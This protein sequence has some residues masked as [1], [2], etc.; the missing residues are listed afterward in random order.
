MSGTGERTKEDLKQAVC[1]SKILEAMLT[2]IAQANPFRQ[3]LC[4]KP[5]GRI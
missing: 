4:H 1:V 3:I 5:V 2:E